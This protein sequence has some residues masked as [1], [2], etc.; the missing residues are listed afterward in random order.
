MQAARAEPLNYTLDPN[1]T[2]PAFEVSHLGL[3]TYRGKFTRVEGKVR[4]DVPAGGGELEVRIDAGSLQSGN[5]QLDGILAGEQFFDV[6]RHPT[7]LFR[8]TRF[9]FEA[10]VP[11]AID[12]ELTLLGTTRALRL[13]LHSFKCMKHPIFVW[14]EVCGADASATIRRS[15]FGMRH[16]LSSVGDEVKLLIPV[17][18]FRD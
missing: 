4:L 3:S 12:G 17:E 15:E 13:T 9:L 8:S 7:M 6:E 1:H 16:H 10:A 18:A 11:V 14:R 5:V 2:Q